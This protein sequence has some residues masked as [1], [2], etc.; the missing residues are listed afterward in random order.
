MFG[1]ILTLL[2]LP[3]LDTSKVRSLRFRPVYKQFFWILLADCILL[4]YIGAQP[5]DGVIHLAAGAELPL[6][7]LGRLGTL[8]YFAHFWIVT[9]IVG[10]IETPKP[11]PDSITKSVLKTQ[12]A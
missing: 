7:W 12:P 5:V 9:P 1:A 8:W 10:W 11:V 2:F 3:W 6:V 4:G